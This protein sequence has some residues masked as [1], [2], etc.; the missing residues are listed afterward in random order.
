VRAGGA[1]VISWCVLLGA[2][3]RAPAGAPLR[4]DAPAERAPA[5]SVT[6]PAVQPELELRMP[7]EST[8][9]PAWVEYLRMERWGDAAR[10]MDAEPGPLREKPE[11]RYARAAAAERLGESARVVELLAGLEKDLP[12]LAD[13]IRERRARAALSAGDPRETLAY[14]KPKT[15]PESQLLTARALQVIE[16]P[17]KARVQLE[18]LLKLLPKRSNP[19]GI[20]AEARALLARV[21]E[22]RSLPL[23]Q[24]EY[25]WLAVQAP[26]CS[27]SDGALERLSALSAPALVRDERRA[28]V[29]AFADAGKVDRAEGELG[30]LVRAKGPPLE[31]GMV[32]YFQGWSRY[33]S[34]SDLGRAVEALSSAA[35]ANSTQAPA[36]LF[37]AGRAASRLGNAD[38]ARALFERVRREHPQSSFAEAGE[39][40]VAQTHY[41]H[42][43][44]AQAA[45]AFDSYLTRRGKKAKFS[46]DAF[47]E[48]AVSWLASGKFEA[49]AR[50]FAELSRSATGLDKARYDELLAVALVGAGKRAEG[51][52]LLRSVASSYPLTFAG[53]MAESRLRALGETPPS[54]DASAAASSSGQ[55][56]PAVPNSARLLHAV[57]LDAEAERELGRAETEIR[58]A[59]PGREDEALCLAYAELAPKSRAYRAGS[60]AATRAELMAKPQPGREWLWDCVYPKPYVA[61]VTE[62]GDLVDVEPELIYAIIRQ[63]SGFRAD[64]VSPAAAVGLMQLLPVTAGRVAAENGLVSEADRLTEPPVNIGYGSRYL[65]KLLDLFGGNYALAAASYN[66]GPT[67]V[68]RWLNGSPDLELDVFVARI[69]FTETRGYVERVV[70]N[71]ARYRYLRGEQSQF[72]LSLA[73]PPAPAPDP[74]SLY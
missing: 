32:S 52:A 46:E 45:A 54:F 73:L 35:R 40:Q 74:A 26:L 24:R 28:R 30:D 50:S 67:A 39:Y 48:R 57:G 59:H 44:F 27:S 51:I 37:Y 43:R 12:V 41:E 65:R 22:T 64:V 7:F 31:P 11:F 34:R 16:G 49:A 1:V 55:L 66:A 14:F 13:K 42:G 29:Q 58:R 61:L 63:E 15:D 10:V 5:A 36:W 8:N 70:G 9:G 62:I 69:P 20:E 2:C 23:A 3:G 38:Q 60:R 21:L 68:L 53:L 71:Y 47:D 6:K 17:D 4:A 25:R 19:C 56:L 72:E 18:A 33:M